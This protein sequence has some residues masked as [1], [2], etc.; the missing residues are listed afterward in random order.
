MFQ[1]VILKFGV[2]Q[3]QFPINLSKT[4]GVNST[5]ATLGLGEVKVGTSWNGVS[6]GALF[7][8]LDL[9]EFNVDSS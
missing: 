8:T 7:P 5:E 6:L 3:S 4:Y 2:N 1:F 9:C